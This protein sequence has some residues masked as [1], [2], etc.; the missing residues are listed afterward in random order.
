MPDT[1]RLQLIEA[2]ADGYC[3]AETGLCAVPP[4]VTAPPSPDEPEEEPAEYSVA[5]RGS[6]SAS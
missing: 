1:P 4:A 6:R 2:E 3:D 5:P